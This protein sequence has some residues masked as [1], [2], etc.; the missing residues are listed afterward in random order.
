MKKVLILLACILSLASCDDKKATEQAVVTESTD[1]LKRIIEQKDNEIQD[2]FATLNEIQEGFL[3]ITAAE[4]RVTLAKSGERSDK[5][6]QLKEDIRFIAQTMQHNRELIE[7][8]KKQAREGSVAAEQ[9]RTTIENL[10]SELKEKNNQ[11]EQLR[12]ELAQRDVRIAELDNTVTTLNTDVATLKTESLEKSQTISSQDK[13]LNTA[14]YV[15]GTKKE[16]TQN[17]I[18]DKGK[19]LQGSFNK[20]YLTKIDI[21]IDKEIK[22]YSKSA[23]ILTTHPTGSYTLQQDASKQYVL[24]ISNPQLFWSTSKYLVVMVK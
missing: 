20:S 21:R 9:L 8:L 2:M 6:E 5:A 17:H 7:K 13:Q 18:L 14:W 4:N 11:L 22:L 15:F 10:T 16:L 3:Q 19:V 24:R 23:K 12:N 1:S